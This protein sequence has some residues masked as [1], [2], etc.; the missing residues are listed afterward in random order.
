LSKNW[1][2]SPGEQQS[3]QGPAFCGRLLAQLFHIGADAQLKFFTRFLPLIF[4]WRVMASYSKV[5]DFPQLRSRVQ[6]LN[7]FHTL[8][9]AESE[10]SSNSSIV[11]LFNRKPKNEEN[12]MQQYSYELINGYPITNIHGRNFLID[13]ALPFTVADRPISIAGKRF[14]VAPEIMGITPS[15]LSATAGIPLD[16]ILGANLI[17]K[18]VLKIQPRQHKLV[19]D[20]YLDAFPLEIDIENL[21]GTAIMHQTIAGKRVK[22]FLTLGTRLSYVMPEMVEERKPIGRERDVL[23]MI[24]EIETEVY[25]LPVAI[26]KRSHHLR[27]AV[28]PAQLQ[29]FI[30][31]ANVTAC[32]GSEL[33]QYY[34]LT[35]AMDEGVLM[36][37]PLQQQ[38]H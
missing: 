31:R 7:P 23:G 25:S 20:R 14:E 12:S 26:G 5:L 8:T 17:E 24:G 37:D 36:L 4:V 15:K 9:A 33:L 32:I 10:I 18:F 34:A 11:R 6:P 19:F 29:D 3:G 1:G 35:L 13:T 27:F 2:F 38:L 22:A 16:G 28:I 21:G 30:E